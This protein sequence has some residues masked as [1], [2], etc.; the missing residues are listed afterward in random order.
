MSVLEAINLWKFFGA[1]EALVDIS[2]KL[3]RGLH[4]LL[5]PNG[6]GKTTLLKI[7]SGL[8][9]PSRGKAYVMDKYIPW[10]D[11]HL[12]MKFMSVVFEDNAIPPWISGKD[13]LRFYAYQ[14]NIKWSSVVEIAEKLG[15]TSYWDRSVAGYSSGMKKKKLLLTV[16]SSENDEIII[17]DEPYTLLDKESINIVNEILEEKLKNVEAIVITSHVLTGI[18]KK[19]NSLTIL[20][21]GKIL[22]HKNIN[23]LYR[24]GEITYVCETNDQLGFL[25][26]LYSEGIRYIEVKNNKIFF[27]TRRQLEWIKEYKCKSFI[28]VREI[29][30]KTLLELSRE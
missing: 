10:R 22:F 2:I 9:K 17:L 29:Y 20:F 3:N 15:V 13:F 19:I 7:W 1:T 23:E 25:E 26:K 18:E 4:L 24:E 6:S 27:K 5:G 21:N 16:L 12:I 30:E 11:R 14:K 8:L 28:D